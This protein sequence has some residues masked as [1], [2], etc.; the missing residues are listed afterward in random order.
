M[1]SIG[2]GQ[3]VPSETVTENV[4]EMLQKNLKHLTEKPK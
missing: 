3:E 1:A 4:T 2:V